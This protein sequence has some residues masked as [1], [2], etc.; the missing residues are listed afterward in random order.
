MP[1]IAVSFEKRGATPL[2]LSMAETEALV[3]RDIDKWTKLIR[4]AGIQAD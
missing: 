1:A 3:A 2:R 4:A